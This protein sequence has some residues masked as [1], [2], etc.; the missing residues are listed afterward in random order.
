LRVFPGHQSQRYKWLKDKKC[1]RMGNHCTVWQPFSLPLF[2]FFL[3]LPKKSTPKHSNFF[4]LFILYQSCFITIQIKNPLQ[5]KT[6]SLF[7]KIIP[8][9]FILYITSITSY[10][11]SNKNST[12]QPFTKHCPYFFRFLA[13]KVRVADC[14]CGSKVD[15]DVYLNLCNTR[16]TLGSIRGEINHGSASSV[17]FFNVLFFLVL[18]LLD[19]FSCIF[20]TT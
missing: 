11:Y 1:T 10:Y 2:S 13:N 17:P 15:M 18:A 20:L 4:S 3:L 7:Y 8:N 5:N 12:T 9:F 14:I 19:G 16:K 6:F